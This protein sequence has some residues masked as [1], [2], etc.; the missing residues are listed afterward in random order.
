MQ[1]AS[2][3][4][5]SDALVSAMTSSWV[6]G[7]NA[8]DAIALGKLLTPDVDFVLVN[9][10]R[11]HGRQDFT[12]VHALQFAQRYRD[13]VFRQDG[14][15]DVS[16]IRPDVAIV[17]WR[18]SISGVSNPD[19]SPAPVYNGIFTWV[20]VEANGVWAIRAAQNTVDR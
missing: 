20:L 18:W 6:D 12:R 1:G 15:T 2:A 4:G 17:H 5:R 10:T 7:W 19:G 16:F 3:D 8:H 14:T 11:L 9:G 13:S